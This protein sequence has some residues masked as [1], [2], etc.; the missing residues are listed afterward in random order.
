MV[1]CLEVEFQSQPFLCYR[2]I[3]PTDQDLPM[4]IQAT[5]FIITCAARTGSTM[6]RF[7]LD[8]H[9]QMVCHGEVF[10]R[11][12]I[13]FVGVSRPEGE[14]NNSPIKQLLEKT[15]NERPVDFLRDYL[16]YAGSYQAIGAKIKYHQLEQ[17]RWSAVFDWLLADR[18]IRVVHLIRE[19]R[20]QRLVSAI[21]TKLTGVTY[22]LAS[23]PQPEPRRPVRKIVVDVESCIRD[24]TAVQAAE[25]RFRRHFSGHRTFEVS[26]EGII[27][28]RSRQLL[29]LQRFLGLEETALTAYTVK[30]SADRLEDVIENYSE[31]RDAL[32]QTEFAYCLPG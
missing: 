13:G 5:R 23:D 19:N 28:E 18:D 17:P 9:P 6:L 29:D 3:D 2:T 11:S 15:R 32:C 21:M 16:F 31:V 4:S 1:R 25:A 27:D 30:Q 22:V 20:L 10:S 12:L 24:F 26:Y 14:D 7:M 8:S